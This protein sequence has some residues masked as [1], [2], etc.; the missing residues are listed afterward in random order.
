MYKTIIQ[1]NH[2]GKD[3]RPLPRARLGDLVGA[4]LPITGTPSQDDGIAG[5]MLL[6]QTATHTPL[7]NHGIYAPW[8]TSNI[9]ACAYHGMVHVQCDS[10]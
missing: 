1:M 6:T 2:T 5:N 8:V 9:H 4:S 3:C 10:V 7:Y